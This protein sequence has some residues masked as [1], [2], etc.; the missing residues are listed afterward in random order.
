MTLE[1]HLRFHIESKGLDS[2]LRMYEFLSNES[3]KT[4]YRT[5]YF[6]FIILTLIGSLCYYINDVMAIFQIKK[7]NIIV[8][9]TI[10][11]LLLCLIYKIIKL[12]NLYSYYFILNNYY[13]DTETIINS[14]R[15]IKVK[16]DKVMYILNT[17]ITILTNKVQTSKRQIIEILLKHDTNQVKYI[18]G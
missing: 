10:G 8:I 5:W 17:L 7:V 11:F 3:L 2:V 12:V 14:L 18:I 4:I 16:E 1:K 6:L 13:N 9:T 15:D